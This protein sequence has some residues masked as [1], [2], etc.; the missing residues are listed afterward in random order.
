MSHAQIVSYYNQHKQA[1][2][3]P[4][5]RDFHIFGA[6][7]EAEAKRAKREIVSGKASR[8]SQKGSRWRLSPPSAWKA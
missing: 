4:E 1:F 5:R 7:S 8:P 6:T 2:G 3:V